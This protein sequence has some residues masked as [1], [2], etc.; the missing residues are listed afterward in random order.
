MNV[1]LST[2]LPL[3]LSPLHPEHTLCHLAFFSSHLS[4]CPFLCHFIFFFYILFVPTA[5]VLPLSL[6]FIFRHV[7]ASILCR[8]LQFTLRLGSR[9]TLSSCP[10]PDQPGE[11]V[12]LHYS[13]DNGITWTLLQHY[14]YQGFHEPRFFL[15]FECVCVHVMC[16][17]RPA[18]ACM[19]MIPLRPYNSINTHIYAANGVLEV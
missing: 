12:L 9:S 4:T 8:Y 3:S 16:V 19:P 11:G 13:S 14:A 1:C 18:H 7:L 17:C 15:C 10:A 2:L 6:V 5:T